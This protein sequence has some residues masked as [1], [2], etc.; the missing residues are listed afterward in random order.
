MLRTCASVK[1]V[2]DRFYP[3]SAFKYTCKG[4]QQAPRKSR[5]AAEQTNCFAGQ[6]SPRFAKKGEEW[7][8][9]FFS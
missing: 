6:E 9:S 1:E 5:L 2:A 8:S 4:T 7:A 3:L